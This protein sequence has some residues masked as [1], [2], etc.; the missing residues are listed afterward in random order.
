MSEYMIVADRVDTEGS[1]VSGVDFNA[2]E[3]EFIYYAVKNV[4]PDYRNMEIENKINQ[5]L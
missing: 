2:V 1:T 5:L 3:W 4:N